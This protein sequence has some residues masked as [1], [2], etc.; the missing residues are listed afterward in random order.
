MVEVMRVANRTKDYTQIDLLIREHIPRFLYN[1]GEGKL[2]GRENDCVPFADENRVADHRQRNRQASEQHVQQGEKSH[3]VIESSGR[4]TH[5]WLVVCPLRILRFIEIDLADETKHVCWDLDQRGGVGEHI[6]HVCFL[7]SSP[8]HT[9][10]A[11][12]LLRYYPKL[13]DDLY[14]GDEY[15]GLFESTPVIVYWSMLICR[16]ECPAHCHRQ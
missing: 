3:S 7:S 4:R 16:G 8:V 10:L 11:K 1:D 15:Y 12:R 14:M 6:L 5:E 9:A 13:I 2:V